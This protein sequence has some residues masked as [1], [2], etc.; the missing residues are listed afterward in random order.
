M[1]IWGAIGTAVGLDNIVCSTMPTCA[2][3]TGIN[4]VETI[5]SGATSGFAQVTNN[6]LK[7]SVF[8]AD[9][10]LHGSF[11]YPVAIS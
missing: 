1:T 6:I 11:S 10:N 9:V 3:S 7:I 5:N 4:L 2:I 8:K